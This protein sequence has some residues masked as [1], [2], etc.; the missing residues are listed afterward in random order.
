ME[1]T[2]QHKG[3]GVFLF[4][5]AAV[6]IAGFISL[7][8]V[9][10]VNAPKSPQ[11]IG[12]TSFTQQTGSGRYT[13]LSDG[14]QNLQAVA[15]RFASGSAYA[16]LQAD[17]NGVIQ[18]VAP[19]GIAASPWTFSST[20]RI[21]SLIETGAVTTYN[22]TSTVAAAELCDSKVW[23]INAAAVS[24]ITLPSTSSAFGSCLTANGDTKRVNIVNIGATN[25]I[26]L[27]GSGGSLKWS[28]ASTTINSGVQA[29]LT[30]FRT[31]TLGYNANLT[32]YPN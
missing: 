17:A 28:L 19:T 16:L 1:S 18:R 25:A 20:T 11:D 30:V 22:S 15:E 9:A 12:Y 14:T 6:A 7:V 27:A 29:T 13:D 32:L 23:V 3:L 31:S 24:T 10:K 2:E 5:L 21:V 4:A 26:L 8:Y